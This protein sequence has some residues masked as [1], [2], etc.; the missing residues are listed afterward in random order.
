MSNLKSA[1]MNVA[2]CSVAFPTVVVSKQ[3]IEGGDID[4]ILDLCFWV[5][6]TAAIAYIGTIYFGRK[7]D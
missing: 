6:M 3:V 1:L 4:E 2:V 5:V 7:S